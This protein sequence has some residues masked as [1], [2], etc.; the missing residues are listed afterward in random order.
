[1][2]PSRVAPILMRVWLPGAGPVPRNTSSRVITIF[3]GWPVRCAIRIAIG[4][5]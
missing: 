2:R 1:M 3:T 4:S 5:R